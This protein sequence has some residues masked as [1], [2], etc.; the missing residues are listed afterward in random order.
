MKVLVLGGAGAV[1]E[2]IC[3]D[4]A[5]TPSIS[6][7]V[8][9]D[10]D[11]NKAKRLIEKLKREK[12]TPTEIDAGKSKELMGALKGV[13]VVINS[14]LPRFNL[15]VMDAALKRGAH[16][17]D[18]AVYSTVDEKLKFDDAWKDAGL[19][20]LLNL[21]EDPGLSNIYAR[22]GADSMDRVEEIRIRDGETC[23][24]DFP[25][26][27]TFSPH[28]F[29]G[30]EIFFEPLI[31]ENGEF[32]HLPPFSG[33]E[34]YEFPD[35]IGPVTVYCTDHE[36][37]ETLPRIIKKGVKYTDFKLAFSPETV[38]LLQT[39]NQ[40][41]LMSSKPIDVRG[42][43]VSPL[44]VFISLIPMPSE[45]AGK[46]KGYACILADVRGEKAGEKIHHLVYTFMSHEDAYKKLGVTATAY[47][48]GIP[49]SVGAAMLAEGKIKRRGVFP[50]EVLE[51][52]PFIKEVR[53][54]GIVTHEKRTVMRS[55]DR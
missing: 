6:E 25:F 30:G 35:P 12:V 44:D 48:T 38:E 46:V 55:L 13:D 49:A 43:K 21:G 51:P 23:E 20:A 14:A 39:L 50:P 34:V 32:K 26:I 3:A 33:R 19:T 36:E 24:G 37:V 2:V 31:F 40:I 28:V 7:V 22:Y 11:L 41:G 45:I 9:A 42:A 54:K 16:Y 29:L 4:L 1:G 15:V 52:E 10:R 53:K 18:N 5:A 27:A 8:C 17:I 47:L